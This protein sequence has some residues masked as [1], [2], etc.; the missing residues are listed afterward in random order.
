M[1]SVL[2]QVSLRE[3]VSIH[4]EVDE[5]VEEEDGKR[6][7][8][9]RPFLFVIVRICRDD[10]LPRP[11]C[12]INVPLFLKGTR[13]YPRE[14]LSVILNVVKNLKMFRS[15]Q[16]DENYEVMGEFHIHM[17]WDNG[18]PRPVFSILFFFDLM[19]D[20]KRK[21]QVFLLRY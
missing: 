4:E 18:F 14:F 16:H 6:G 11:V 7:R 21:G 20:L 8:D 13:L 10:G 12:I 2:D 1:D 19:V 9:V 17:I 5:E 3:G 15:A